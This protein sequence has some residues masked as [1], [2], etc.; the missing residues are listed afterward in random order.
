MTTKRRPWTAADENE[1]W[2]RYRAGEC[3]R[4][5]ALAMKRDIANVH[6]R[7]AYHGGIAPPVRTRNAR[8]LS[9]REREAISRGVA[10]DQ[11]LSSIAASLGRP[12]S[13]VSREVNRNGGRAC[14]LAVAADQRAWQNA[15]R[16]KW[17]KM[18]LNCRLLD[19]VAAKLEMQWSPQQISG[20]LKRRYP[21]NPRM[22]ISHETIYRTLFM[23]ARGLLKKELVGHLRRGRAMR[24]SRR[25]T[26]AGGRRG[27]ISDPVSIRERPAEADDRAV[28]GHWEGDLLVGDTASCMVT[29]VERTSRFVQLIKVDARDSLTVVS[30]IAKHVRKLP[31]ELRRS[32]TWDRGSELARHKEF[33]VATDLQVYFADPQSPWQRGS[34]ENTN[35]LLRQYFPK[36]APVGD[37]SQRDLN[38]VARR[39][40]T[41]PR[42]TLDFRTPAEVLASFVAPTT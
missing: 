41:R 13:T 16:P 29:L 5:I 3:I 17:E 19:I 36:G 15:Q 37:V 11:S 18:A 23:Q 20:W 10:S 34:N 42:Q 6:V 33:K 9:M 39:L 7:V 26:D 40:N 1:L 31:A 14:Y 2:R 38:R 12:T 4:D 22:Q 35:G 30:A 28:P 32:L 25:A 8:C 21:A 27:G 24:R